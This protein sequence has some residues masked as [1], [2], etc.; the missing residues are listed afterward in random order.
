VPDPIRRD[1]PF[2]SLIVPTYNEA[3]NIVPLA[4]KARQAL[5]GVP[6][7]ILVVDD[8]SPD[9][10]WAKAQAYADQLPDRDAL[11]VI[12]R[13][14]GRGLSS[15]VIEGFSQA[16]GACLG[17]IDADLS[18]DETI[19]PR[20]LDAVRRGADMA[21]GSRRV[22]GGGADRWPW[23][24]RLFSTA[25]T[26][27]SRTLLG[28]S[29]HDPMSGF[30]VV[31]RPVF[32]ACRTRLHPRG[33]KILLEILVKSHVNRVV[34]VPY[35]FKD[36]KQ[37]YSKLS[38]AVIFYFLLQCASL[39]INR[40]VNRARR[41]WHESRYDKVLSL[42]KEGSLVDLGCGQPCEAMPDG[43]FLLRARRGVGLDLKSCRGALPF[44]QGDLRCLPFCP[45]SVDNI[46]AMEVLEHVADPAG[47]LQEIRRVLKDGGI[48]VM[49]VPRETWL[50]NRL[51]SLWE[52]TFGKIW[53]H[54]HV[55]EVPHQAWR[56]LL[57]AHFRVRRE[58]RHL[59]YIMIFQAVKAGDPAS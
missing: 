51:W 10:T 57:D 59:R 39:W 5:R 15:A 55:G 38:G 22:A 4:E 6:H 44:V 25:A 32:E 14:R 16:R 54:T 29:I 20:L 1:A 11:R 34:E 30:F 7:E 13:R 50:W 48:F 40:Q 23:H 2:F 17:V 46:V 18:H 19:L 26:G 58:T 24:R 8:D 27:F 35:V 53:L 47:A 31:Q 52:R 49:S 37:G 28:L 56:P 21:V 36:R 33:Y 45:S 9:R 42:L 43:S 3:D 41:F 12:R